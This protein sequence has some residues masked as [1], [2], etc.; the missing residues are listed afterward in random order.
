M[1]TFKF[2]FDS[3]PEIAS[4][5]VTVTDRDAILKSIIWILATPAGGPI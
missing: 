4:E 5:T 3:E 1:F 2:E